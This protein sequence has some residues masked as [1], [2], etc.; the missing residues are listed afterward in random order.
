V[1]ARRM[2]LLGLFAVAA[3][4]AV[5]AAGAPADTSVKDYV[6]P[7]GGA[8]AV[9]ALF[10]ANDKVPEASN[11]GLFYR[12]VGIPDGLG[13][14]PNGNGTSTLYMNHEVGYA[15]TSSPVV[16]GAGNPVGPAYRG[17][18]VSKWTLDADGNPTKGERAYDTIWEENTLLGPAP[19]TSNVA[20]MPRQFGRFC[21]GGLHGTSDGYDRP[22]YFAN[23]EVGAAE[24]FDGKAGSRSRSSTTSSTP[25]RS[26]AGSRGSRPSRSRTRSRAR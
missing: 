13:A 15:A 2:L 1:T 12:M 5:T 25:C 19:D 26:S 10:S 6:A 18:V 16:D 9:G 17:A 20:Q 11:P 23:E 7:V 22:I 24:S 3:A 4:A 14:M 21:S 8:Y